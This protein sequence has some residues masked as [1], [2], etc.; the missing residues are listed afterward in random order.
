M[1]LV[2]EVH[3]NCP[4]NVGFAAAIQVIRR[5]WDAVYRRPWKLV[6]FVHELQ[7]DLTVWVMQLQLGIWCACGAPHKRPCKVHASMQTCGVCA[8]GAMPFN[9][10]RGD[11]TV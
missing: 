4:H 1:R 5:A 8:G 7:C 9:A 2:Q 3:S 11:L 6:R 10:S